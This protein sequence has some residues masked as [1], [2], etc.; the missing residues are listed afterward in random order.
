M[1]VMYCPG[2]REPDKGLSGIDC[3]TL[4]FRTLVLGNIIVF[5]LWDHENRKALR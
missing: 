1:I 2:T 4:Y 3:L 5:L